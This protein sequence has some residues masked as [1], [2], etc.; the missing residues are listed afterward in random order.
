MGCLAAFTHVGRAQ[1]LHNTESSVDPEW[2]RVAD[3]V[4]LTSTYQGKER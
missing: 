4:A 3:L 2:I 1:K